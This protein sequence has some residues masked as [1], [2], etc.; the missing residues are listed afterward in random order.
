[1]EKTQKKV[2]ESL[3]EKND[4]VKAL[5]VMEGS[6]LSQRAGREIKLLQSRLD[7][8]RSKERK[9]L[10]SYGELDLQKNKVRSAILDILENDFSSSEALTKPSSGSFGDKKILWIGIIVIIIFLLGLVFFKG[11][12]T[13]GIQGDNNDNNE[14]IIDQ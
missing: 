12:Q 8:L 2:V 11:S 1:M 10:M 9:G 7:D 4:L 6:A 5:K 13:I 14:V 3:V